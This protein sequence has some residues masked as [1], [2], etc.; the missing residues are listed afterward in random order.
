[1]TKSGGGARRSRGPTGAGVSET[2][3]AEGGGPELTSRPTGLRRADEPRR[4]ARERVSPRSR[5]S[6]CSSSRAARVPSAAGVSCREWSFSANG[7]RSGLGS[8]GLKHQW[9]GSCAAE[10]GE[11]QAYGP[12]TWY[13]QSEHAEKRDVTAG[14]EYGSVVARPR[15]P[16]H[17]WQR[18][19]PCSS[20]TE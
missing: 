19:S 8:A 7:Q 5:L 1:M 3:A 6:A 10:A 14:M 16:S 11:G 20:R 15:L 2:A 12:V 17:P 18:C 4:R 13:L 9:G